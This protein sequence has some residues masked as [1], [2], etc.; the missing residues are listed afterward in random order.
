M[1]DEYLCLN[2][3]SFWKDYLDETDCPDADLEYE[4]SEALLD[5]SDLIFEVR[6]K[7]CGFR[8]ILIFAKEHPE[9]EDE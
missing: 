1:E 2:K 3:L 6:K 8:N 7:Y 4:L 9:E 5:A